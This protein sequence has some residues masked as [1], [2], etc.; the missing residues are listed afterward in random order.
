MDIEAVKRQIAELH[1]GRKWILT[2]DVAAA[3][4]P[5]VEQ[6]KEWGVDGI[7]L[8]AGIEGGFGQS[9]ILGHLQG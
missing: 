9:P 7:M 8:I 5:M 4:G 2:P 1:Q 6:L 3:A